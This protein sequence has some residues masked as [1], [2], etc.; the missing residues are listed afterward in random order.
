MHCH[1]SGTCPVTGDLRKGE[2]N[3]HWWT[4]R[5]PNEDGESSALFS[6]VSSGSVKSSPSRGLVSDKCPVSAALRCVMV[7][8]LLSRALKHRSEAGRCPMCRGLRW[9]FCEKQRSAGFLQAW[10]VGPLAARPMATEHSLFHKAF[11]NGTELRIDW[12]IKAFWP[13]AQE[14]NPVFFPRSNGSM[15][16]NQRSRATSQNHKYCKQWE[17]TTF[18]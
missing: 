7:A 8:L 15:F 16:A 11:S 1:A 6:G 5:F 17:L 12:L 4:C 10:A 3:L 2:G 18:I 14:P 9:A 13:E